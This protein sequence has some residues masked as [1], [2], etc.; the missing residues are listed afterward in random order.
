MAD[1]SDPTRVDLPR[2]CCLRLQRHAGPFSHA[3]PRE[4]FDQRPSGIREGPQTDH[5]LRIREI[6]RHQ[7]MAKELL[8]PDPAPEGFSGSSG[9]VY[10]DES[11]SEKNVQGSEELPALWFVCCGLGDDKSAERRMAASLEEKPEPESARLKAAAT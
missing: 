8:R 3:R 11:G 6:D 1:S 5:G 4:R 7:L 10:L 2:L 9:G